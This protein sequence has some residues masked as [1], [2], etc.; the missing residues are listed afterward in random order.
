[1]REGGD[2]TRVWCTSAIAH[3]VRLVSRM[4]GKHLKFMS[5]ESGI[6]KRLKLPLVYRV[7]CLYEDDDIV[8]RIMMIEDA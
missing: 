1:M 8:R 6:L 4:G 3:F 5:S 7:D 2:E